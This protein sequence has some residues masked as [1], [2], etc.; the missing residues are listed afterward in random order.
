VGKNDGWL[1]SSP[2]FILIIILLKI[3]RFGASERKDKTKFGFKFQKKPKVMSV[4]MVD[5]T[6]RRCREPGH[7]YDSTTRWVPKKETGG[8]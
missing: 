8:D 2:D 4:R 3:S 1:S 6:I 7:L 5:R